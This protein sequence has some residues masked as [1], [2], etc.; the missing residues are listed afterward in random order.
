M[1]FDALSAIGTPIA[2]PIPASRKTSRNTIQT[3][4]PGCAPSAIRIPIS[5]GAAHDVVRHG[6]VQADTRDHQGQNGEAG[7]EIREDDLLVHGLVDFGSLCFDIRQREARIRLVHELAYRVD[8]EERIAGSAQREG[9][10]VHGRKSL[11][12]YME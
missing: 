9:H 8:V 7:A 11:P 1:N 2:S 12:G 6:P 10:L 5:V 3:T 4:A